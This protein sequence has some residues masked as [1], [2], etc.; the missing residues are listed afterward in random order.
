MAHKCAH[1]ATWVYSEPLA[2]D[3]LE[4]VSLLRHAVAVDASVEDGV[5]T[6]VMRDKVGRLEQQ[7]HV[8]WGRA[9][10]GGR[11]GQEPGRVLRSN[12]SFVHSMKEGGMVACPGRAFGEE[13]FSLGNTALYLFITVRI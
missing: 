11:R 12:N 1:F 3:E 4:P 7:V 5:G 9:L 2:Q 8:G 6:E 13:K 10:Q